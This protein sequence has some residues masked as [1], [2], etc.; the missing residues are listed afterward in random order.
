MHCQR[1]MMS[2]C[3]P[4]RWIKWKVDWFLSY[5]LD[6]LDHLSFPKVTSFLGLQSRRVPPPW[7]LSHLFS[8]PQHKLCL[9]HIFPQPIDP[10][11]PFE[12]P[13]HV[14]TTIYDHFIQW[15]L[16]IYTHVL[17]SIFDCIYLII[18]LRKNTWGQEVCHIHLVFL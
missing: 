12:A 15:M 7:L 11:S 17:Y 10:M 6:K 16:I 3:G 4:Y 18:C 14:L 2:H 8:K 5:S 13:K 9:P 1:L